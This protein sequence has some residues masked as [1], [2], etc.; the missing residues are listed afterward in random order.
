M[1]KMY[2]ENALRNSGIWQIYEWQ[3]LLADP[4]EFYDEMMRRP[5]LKECGDAL[6]NIV[7][8]REKMKC[9]AQM[10]GKKED[11]DMVIEIEKALWVCQNYLK[12][13]ADFISD[14]H[15]PRLMRKWRVSQKG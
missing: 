13:V 9:H 4:E 6:E 12:R 5:M 14:I 7:S 15:A 2:F 3:T 10:T 11:Y 1:Y 8:V